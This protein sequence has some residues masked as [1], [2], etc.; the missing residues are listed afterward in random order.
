MQVVSNLS[1]SL[2]GLAEHLK[3][4]SGFS[5]QVFFMISILINILTSLSET[6][7][8]NCITLSTQ[9]NLMQSFKNVKRK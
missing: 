5:L 1:H 6:H 2:V 7:T 3:L 8:C 4:I 9:C